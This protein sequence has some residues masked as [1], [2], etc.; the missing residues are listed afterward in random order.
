MNF[1]TDADFQKGEQLNNIQKWIDIPK[2]KYEILETKS[3]KAKYGKSYIAKL[4]NELGEQLNVWLPNRIGNNVAETGVPCF[5]KHH[6]KILNIDNTKFFH[7]YSI[8][9]AGLRN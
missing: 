7:K 3:V 5:I 9:A 4:R 2:V 6:G 1:P 8:L